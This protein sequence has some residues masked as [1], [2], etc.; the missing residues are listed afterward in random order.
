MW[1]LV[2]N[3]NAMWQSKQIKQGT[4][5]VCCIV[6]AIKIKIDCFCK[7]DFK[8]K[9]LFIIDYFSFTGA[10]S[11]LITSVSGAPTDKGVI[12]RAGIDAYIYVYI[13]SSSLLLFNLIT[14]MKPRTC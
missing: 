4:G 3:A 1:K 11:S 2:E 9:Y 13:L 7:C 14:I 10:Y 8:L 6:E 12:M 5:L